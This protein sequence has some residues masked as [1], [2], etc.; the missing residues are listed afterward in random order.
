MV[1]TGMASLAGME[2]LVAVNL[3]PEMRSAI[4][5]TSTGVRRARTRR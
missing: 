4:V 3:K 5:A 1:V 2:Q